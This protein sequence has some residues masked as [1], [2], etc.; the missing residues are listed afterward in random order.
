MLAHSDYGC[1]F[2]KACWRGGAGRQKKILPPGC[3]TPPGLDRALGKA[4][5]VGEGASRPLHAS[6]SV[7]QKGRGSVLAKL[8]GGEF[9]RKTGSLGNSFEAKV[10]HHH[11]LKENQGAECFIWPGRQ[12][13]YGELD[14][15]VPRK[16]RREWPLLG[17]DSRPGL[18]LYKGYCF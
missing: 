14:L 16:T 2:L 1:Q 11:S 13:S 4:L 6:E 12:C 5:Y 8:C 15:A 7:L 3:L 17:T 10:R 9:L 18:Q